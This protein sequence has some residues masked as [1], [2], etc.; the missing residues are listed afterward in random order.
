MNASI[1]LAT[2]MTNRR[3]DRLESEALSCSSPAR[4]PR[5]TVAANGSEG[6]EG[7]AE[8]LASPPPWLELPKDKDVSGVVSVWPASEPPVDA[9]RDCER[10]LD[11]GTGVC[12]L[13]LSAGRIPRD[14]STFTHPSNSGTVELAIGCRSSA[15]PALLCSGSRRSCGMSTERSPSATTL[16]RGVVGVGDDSSVGIF[17]LDYYSRCVDCGLNGREV[18]PEV[19]RRSS[20]RLPDLLCG[21]VV[22]GD[23]SSQ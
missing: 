5:P 18:V 23:V 2:I 6:V 10:E 7:P 17:R 13:Y 11:D 22:S 1:S 19:Y 4:V 14:D 3:S 9:L 12:R 16:G 21:F 20:D 8:T 15:D